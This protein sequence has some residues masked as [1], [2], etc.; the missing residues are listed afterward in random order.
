MNIA[1]SECKRNPSLQVVD[2]S[3]RL[4]TESAEK[5]TPELL[6][7]IEQSTAGIIVNL[8]AVDYISSSGLRTLLIAYQD[9][10]AV[11]KKIALIHTQPQ[12][13]KIFKV[14]GFDTIFNISADQSEALKTLWE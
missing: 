4:D 12:V 6:R 3:G 8:Q 9:A 13:H 11:G 5:V 1:V 7:T 10:Q 2:L 14:A